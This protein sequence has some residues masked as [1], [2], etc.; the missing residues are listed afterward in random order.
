MAKYKVHIDDLPV[1]QVPGRE[2]RNAVS[3]EASGSQQMTMQIVDVL[4]G[5]VS[6][7]GHIHTDCEEIIF[8]HS[9]AGDIMIGD[10]VHHMRT[11]DIVFLPRGVRHMTRNPGQERMRLICAFS[12]CDLKTG[13]CFHPQMAYPAK[14]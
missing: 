6:K 8:V 1:M 3:K 14:N 11:G 9:G 12:S 10:Q 2:V 5:A 13:M 4:P 7:P